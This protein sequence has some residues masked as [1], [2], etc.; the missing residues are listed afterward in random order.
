MNILSEASKERM[1]TPFLEG[2]AYGWNV[3]T[4]PAGEPEAGKKE[5]GHGG[6]INGFNTLIRRVPEDRSLIV[7]LNNTGGT[8]LG[9]IAR[10]IREGLGGQEPAPPKQGIADVIA[11]VLLEQ[12]AAAAVERYR[13][14][15][16]T[17]AADF[18]FEEFR[19]NTIGY[20]L[21]G[22][23]R[24]AEAIVIFKLNVEEY[25]RSGNVYDSLGEA[26]LKAGETDLAVV[27]YRKSL[28]L[29]PD[30]QNAREVLK[31]LEAPT[32]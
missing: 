29:S 30:N 20:Q 27:N 14:L 16:T 8:A 3:R 9:A 21:L 24:T 19:L 10:G 15:K 32:P 12:G 11:P 4:I 2:Y 25:P 26:Y 31:K 1:F 13:T 22:R 28:E 7:L 6:G 5:I 18:S 23:G 17:R